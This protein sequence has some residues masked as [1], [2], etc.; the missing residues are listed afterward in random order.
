MGLQPW[1]EES[2][3]AE[4]VRS[5]LGA[6]VVR[7][8]DPGGGGEQLHDFDVE[9]PDGDV[10]AVEVTRDTVPSHRRVLAEV[11]RRNWQFRDLRFDWVVD[12]I[13]PY[14]VRSVHGKVASPLVAL[15]A[16]GVDS[17]LL[18]HPNALEDAPTA[19]ELP[20]GPARQAGAE[21]YA[22]RARLV[23]RLSEA[24]TGGGVVIMSEASKASSTAP[25]VV[26][27]LIE[28]HAALDDNLRKLSRAKAAS[29]RH[30]FVWIENSSQQAVATMAF[31]FLPERPPKLPDCVDAAWAVTAYVQARVW[32]YHRRHGWRDLGTWRRRE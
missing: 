24:E 13:S 6:S 7:R 11:D 31:G 4:L 2:D 1:D 22:L 17:A 15:E 5:K 28:R 19:D 14:D 29:E 3:A 16:V 12:M 25:S 9:L 18:R 32:Q 10:I 26:V 20:E 30:L 8:V 21:L 27:E 23:Y